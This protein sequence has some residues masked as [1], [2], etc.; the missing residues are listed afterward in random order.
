MNA[1]L[2]E[3]YESIRKWP[4]AKLIGQ[5]DPEK[6]GM[7][8]FEFVTKHVPVRPNMRILDL[9]CGLG[10]SSAPFVDYLRDEGH[11]VGVD[12]VERM[13]S[14]CRE[15][16][17]SRYPNSNFYACA[18]PESYLREQQREN[19]TNLPSIE[20]VLAQH[21]PFDL[22]LAFS[23]FTHLLP[24]EM[25]AYFSLFDRILKADG[26]LVLTFL[27]LDEWTRPK[28][29]NRALPTMVAGD[30]P[31]RVPE[32]GRVCFASPSNPRAAVAIALEDVLQMVKT[33][34]FQPLADRFRIMAGVNVR[35]RSRRAH[36]AACER[37]PGP[38]RLRSDTVSR[39]ACRCCALGYRSG[40]PL[41]A[42]G[43][44]G[45]PRVPVTSESSLANAGAQPESQLLRI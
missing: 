21:A 35:D 26:W 29:R 1:Q 20:E 33:H 40:P 30:T 28:I 12:V 43:Q 6:V 41:F 25:D 15:V 22:V 36:S 44:T 18:A 45:G 5:G 39:A 2:K 19:P 42:V 13:A 7:G 34:G 27:F 24:K 17:G 23:V 3:I 32:P 9:G 14:F 38:G 10:R 37:E 4:F 16:I 31:D 11:L 8:L